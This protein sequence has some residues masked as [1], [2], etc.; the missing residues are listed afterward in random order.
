M[1]HGQRRRL[2]DVNTSL[3]QV[4]PQTVTSHTV[5]SEYALRKRSMRRS[6]ELLDTISRLDTA[7]NP[8]TQKELAD[9]LNAMYEER[10]GGP[11][12]GLFGHCYLG[13]PYIDHQMDLVGNISRHFRE[14]DVPPPMFA[15]ARPLAR[16]TSYLYI[17]VYADGQIVPIRPDG[18]SAL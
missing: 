13:A 14:S 1:Q 3:G 9:W 5:T 6:A 17:E 8:A 12:K 2:V 16:S 10:G 7:T 11:L 18:T 15:A 4:R